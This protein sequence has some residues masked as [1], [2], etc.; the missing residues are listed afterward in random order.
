MSAKFLS[1]LSVAAVLLVWLSPVARPVMAQ[2]QLPA[3]VIADIWQDGTTI[4]YRIQNIGQAGVGSVQAP[5]S[6]TMLSL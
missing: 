5:S 6:F 2:Q 4:W 1:T 3:L